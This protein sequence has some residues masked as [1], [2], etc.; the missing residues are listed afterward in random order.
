MDDDY[1]VINV[2]IYGEEA[3]DFLLIQMAVRGLAIDKDA[4]KTLLE[5]VDEYILIKVECEDKNGEEESSG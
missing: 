4:I 1:K 3:L 5:L 2:D